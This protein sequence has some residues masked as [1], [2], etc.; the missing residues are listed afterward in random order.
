M[1]GCETLMLLLVLPR[2]RTAR[3]LGLVRQP[4]AGAAWMTWI[5][6]RGFR[7]A[8][9]P[10]T[11]RFLFPTSVYPALTFPFSGAFLSRS[12]F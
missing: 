10:W 7:L 8:P 6:P 1:H 2:A 5:T 12:T 9:G 4:H 3:L 11:S